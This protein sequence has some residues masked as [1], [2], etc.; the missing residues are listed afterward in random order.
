M[1][2]LSELGAIQRLL[3]YAGTAGNNEDG[4]RNVLGQLFDKVAF[5]RRRSA[6]AEEEPDFT[7]DEQRQFRRHGLDPE[8]LRFYDTLA[9]YMHGRRTQHSLLQ[10]A[11]RGRLSPAPDFE[12]DELSHYA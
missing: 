4:E 2:E 10:D 11:I 5:L 3:P 1:A 8:S 7:A 12:I 6:A 9:R